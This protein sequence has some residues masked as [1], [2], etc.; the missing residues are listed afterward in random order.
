ML[1]LAF[2]TVFGPGGWP[3]S[4][5]ASVRRVENRPLPLVFVFGFY[6]IAEHG[7][8]NWLVAL[9][10]R[11]FG[12]AGQ[13]IRPPG[14]GFW[15]RDAA[16]P[17]GALS[18]AGWWIGWASPRAYVFCL[19]SSAVV[20]YTSSRCCRRR[21]GNAAGGQRF[22]PLSILYPTLVMSIR[23]FFRMGRA[24]GGRHIISVAAV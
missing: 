3:V 16:G 5:K 21:G 2:S 17:S 10:Q 15:R 13:S 23:L 14:R 19:R 7:V 22:F 1:L 4:G 11:A 8:M 12:M 18:W 6:F 9:R 20:L 24:Q